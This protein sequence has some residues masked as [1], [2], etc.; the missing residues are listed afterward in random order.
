MKDLNFYILI[1]AIIY[2]CNAGFSQ[3]NSIYQNYYLTPFVINPAITGAEIYTVADLSV[4]QQWLGIS[5]A[6]VTY[7]LS[8]NFRLGKYDFYDP[9]GFINKGPLNLVDRIGLGA[10][11]YR[12][13][14]GPENLTGG[15]VSYAYHLPLNHEVN[16]SFGISVMGAYYSF[17]NQLLNPNQPGDYYLLE[18]VNNQF[19]LNFG[20]GSYL[21]CNNY[22]V[23]LS[24]N[25]IL[26]DISSPLATKGIN[27]SYFIFGG[28]KFLA[29]SNSFNFE[30]SL[31]IRKTG[32]QPVTADLHA[33]LYIK[34]YNW[35]SASYSTTGNV[36]F[37]F[38]VRLHKM[39]YAGYNAGF[40]LSKVSA[41]SFGTHEIHLGINLG[42]TGVQ[43]VR[44]RVDK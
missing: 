10:A 16:L 2:G 33:K 22:F 18:D 40:P 35:F 9:K 7:Q 20:A 3:E 8:G 38:G 11:V 23:G 24:A 4:K 17:N 26:Q 29:E 25:K 6:P 42:L 36:N 39:L 14:N 28:Y 34:R 37:R 31:A 15:L 27:P 1:L 13:V 5:D 30:P 43:G 12:D 21:Y 44:E 19:R 32:S 41:Y